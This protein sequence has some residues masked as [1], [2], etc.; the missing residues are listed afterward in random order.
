MSIKFQLRPIARVCSANHSQLTFFH[1]LIQLDWLVVLDTAHF[2]CVFFCFSIE[3]V[4]HVFIQ[5]F[6]L[7]TTDFA[8]PSYEHLFVSSEFC[9]GFIS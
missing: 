3:N 9:N 6:R 2:V 4:A 8:P 1:S 7:V 5:S